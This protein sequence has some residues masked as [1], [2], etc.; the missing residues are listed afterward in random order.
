MNLIRELD[1]AIDGLLG[2]GEVYGLE[3]PLGSQAVELL[4]DKTHSFQVHEKEVVKDE[5]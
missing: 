4:G 1:G 3:E 2:K 5:A